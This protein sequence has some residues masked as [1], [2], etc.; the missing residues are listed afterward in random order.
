MPV[1][2]IKFGKER[3][4]ILRNDILYVEAHNKHSIIYLKNS[5]KLESN[6]PLKLISTQLKEPRFYR[7]HGSFVINCSCIK[8]FN[9][10]HVTLNGDIK[11]SFS[12][13]KRKSFETNLAIYNNKIK[14]EAITPK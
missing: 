11:V 6:D 12:R 3:I 2:I 4:P 8:S 7:I 14:E 1:L 9:T 10:H 13:N 5:M